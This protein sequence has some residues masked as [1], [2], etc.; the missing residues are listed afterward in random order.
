MNKFICWCDNDI[1]MISQE[2]S[3]TTGILKFNYICS[4]CR[5]TFINE[6]NLPEDN[7]FFYSLRSGNCE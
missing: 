5:T 1:F 3:N 4:R 7:S 2:D 6:I